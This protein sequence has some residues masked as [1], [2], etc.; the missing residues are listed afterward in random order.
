[1]SPPSGY[2]SASLPVFTTWYEVPIGHVGIRLT[3]IREKTTGVIGRGAVLRPRNEDAIFGG[4]PV[5][6]T[7]VPVIGGYC[8]PR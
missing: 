1:M 4:Y 5:V 3:Q 6:E 8:L 7:A 2:S